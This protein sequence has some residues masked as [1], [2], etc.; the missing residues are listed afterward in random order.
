MTSIK[1]E[2]KGIQFDFGGQNVVNS[3]ELGKYEPSLD[4]EQQEAAEVLA[5]VFQ[6][7][8]VVTISYTYMVKQ[9]AKKEEPIEA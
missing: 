5:K 3:L 4:Y 2:S 6:T 1:A 8:V 9:P 7:D